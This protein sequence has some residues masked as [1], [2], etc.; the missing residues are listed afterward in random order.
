MRNYQ[1]TLID[2]GKLSFGFA[3]ENRYESL[4]GECWA[5]IPS[6]QVTSKV[7]AL[8]AEGKRYRVRR[9]PSFILDEAQLVDQT[10]KKY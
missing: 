5:S 1:M 3:I 2:G 7:M 4:C 6:L 8:I 9:P 10:L